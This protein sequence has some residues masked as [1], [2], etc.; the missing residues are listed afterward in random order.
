MDEPD[1]GISLLKEDMLPLKDVKKYVV[2]VVFAVETF[3]I[4]FK[5]KRFHDTYILYY[6]VI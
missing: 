5:Q 3:N 4:N 2:R 6:Q 1:W